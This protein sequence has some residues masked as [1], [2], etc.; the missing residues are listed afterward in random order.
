MPP[1]WVTFYTKNPYT[2]VPL[3]SKQS[4]QESPISQNLWKNG[5]INRCLVKTILIGESH[6]SKFVKKMVKSTVVW[7]RKI[8]R[9]GS[10]IAKISKKTPVYSALFWVR[11]S[12]D[13]GRG[14]GPRRG[15]T[16]RQKIIRVALK[17]QYRASPHSSR[18]PHF[19]QKSWFTRPPFEKIWTF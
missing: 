3:W 14:L 1:K 11:K 18:G 10:R 7:G 12:L 19:D 8:L 4:L 17:S 2:W 16:I 6:F 9:N 15:R 13:T 5:K